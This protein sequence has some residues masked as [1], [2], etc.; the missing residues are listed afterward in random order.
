MSILDNVKPWLD[1]GE[2]LQYAIQCQTG[3]SPA[4]LWVPLL[5][6]VVIANRARI[7]VFTDRRIAVFAAGQLRPNRS[8][9]KRLLY[10][11]PRDT[12]LPHDSG[13]YSRIRVGREH[14]WFGSAVYPYLDE[15]TGN[16][17]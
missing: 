4:L 3:V 8:R 11:L 12:K 1:P 10:S 7:V 14:I 6:F 16:S 9:P 15:A 5:N 17:G 2:Q 13:S